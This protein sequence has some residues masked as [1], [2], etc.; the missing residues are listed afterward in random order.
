MG[1]VHLP[2]S[3]RIECFGEG[4]DWHNHSEVNVIIQILLPR[5]GNSRRFTTRRTG[6][7]EHR[8]DRI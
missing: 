8:S 7:I 3:Q 2:G 1:K 4:R 6:S 5:A